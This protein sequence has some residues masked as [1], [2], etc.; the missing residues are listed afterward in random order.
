MTR[1]RLE[2]T[3]E[4]FRAGRPGP[5][6]H[7]A[8]AEVRRLGYDV[9]VGPFGNAVELDRKAA[10]GMLEAVCSA[11]L[12][13][14]ASGLSIQ[15]TAL[16]DHAGHPAVTMIEPVVLALGG[17]IVAPHE[18]GPGDVPL[19]WEGEVVAG[20]RLPALQGALARLVEQ[21]EHELGRPLAELSREDKQTA[22]GMLDDRG[23]FELR[24]SV[25]VVAARMGVSRMTLYNYLG[26][27]R[28]AVDRRRPTR[29]RS[30]QSRGRNRA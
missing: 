25:E 26:A 11:A 10:P 22:A 5:H 28:P 6:V 2:F 16:D 18:L 27:A 13:K 8:L 23:A 30:S 15:L 14:G 4:P 24:N 1:I 3:V 29:T 17:T 7:A 12:E 19:R 20:V 9:E 21:V